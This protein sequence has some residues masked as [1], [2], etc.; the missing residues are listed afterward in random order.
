MEDEWDAED[1]EYE[2]GVE[3]ERAELNSQ[4]NEE[5]GPLAGH[6]DLLQ[7]PSESL[8]ILVLPA[9]AAKPGEK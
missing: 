8:G 9:I 3:E 2:R 4:L 7:S 1:E 5:K 6:S